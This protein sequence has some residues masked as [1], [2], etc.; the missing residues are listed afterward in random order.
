M[1]TRTEK[2]YDDI[3]AAF[4]QLDEQTQEAIAN[5]IL[6]YIESGERIIKVSQVELSKQQ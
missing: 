1:E 2:L 6:S 5:Y 4:K 3:I